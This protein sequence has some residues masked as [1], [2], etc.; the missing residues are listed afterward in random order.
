M[1]ISQRAF[2]TVLIG[3]VAILVAL[4]AAANHLLPAIDVHDLSGFLS[5]NFI[6]IITPLTFVFTTLNAFYD[7]VDQM[8]ADGKL[9][10]GDIQALFT[11]SSFYVTVVAAV[12]G[13][14]QVFGIS[15]INANDQA[16]L[17]NVLLL[18]ATVLLRSFSSRAPQS[19]APVTPP[20]SQ[21][22]INTEAPAGVG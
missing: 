2:T 16:M 22:T 6:T 15:V 12:S 4:Y 17:V 11:M 3:I 14:F 20:V 21:V 1:S 5:A 19:P 10:P 13:L 18:G 9:Q 8:I 7:S